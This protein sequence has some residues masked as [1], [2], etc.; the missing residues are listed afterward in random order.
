MAEK[1]IW[2]VILAVLTLGVAA[3]CGALGR[4]AKVAMNGEEYEYICPEGT[5]KVT[6]YRDGIYCSKDL[7]PAYERER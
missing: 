2:V 1:I 7:V 3:S 5:T 4:G 6:L